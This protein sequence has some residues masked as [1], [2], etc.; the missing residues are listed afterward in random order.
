MKDKCKNCPTYEYGKTID[1]K[2]NTR[3][4]C[5]LNL[6]CYECEMKEKESIKED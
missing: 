2:E 4:W 3:D 6:V 5:A 1:E